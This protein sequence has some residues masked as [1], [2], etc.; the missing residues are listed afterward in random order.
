MRNDV[1]GCCVTDLRLL[2]S[3]RRGI[4][5]SRV[6]P[7]PGVDR[8]DLDCLCWIVLWEFVVERSGVV[9]GVT[10]MLVLEDLFGVDGGLVCDCVG[11][12]VVEDRS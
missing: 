1:I 9:G 3:I 6:D 8:T 10:S 11:G 2:V 4:F 12:D 7:L 5:R